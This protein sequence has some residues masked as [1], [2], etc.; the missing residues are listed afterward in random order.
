MSRIEGLSGARRGASLSSRWHG[1]EEAIFC[2]FG[3]TH[4]RL[5]NA[6]F[7]TVKI[8]WNTLENRTKAFNMF[9]LV[10]ITAPAA[11]SSQTMN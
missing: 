6:S 8:F 7:L 5:I 11:C 9:R 4:H 3:M 2:S 1:I 10:L